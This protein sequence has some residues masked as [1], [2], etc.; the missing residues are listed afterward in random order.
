[1]P[2][3]ARGVVGYHAIIATRRQLSKRPSFSLNTNER[4]ALL[5]IARRAVDGFVRDGMIPPIDSAGL[6]DALTTPCG[7]FVTLTKD[8][9][10]RGCVG[11]FDPSDPLYRVVQQMA[12]ASATQDTRFDPVMPGELRDLEIEVSVLS[13]MKKVN[14]ID[15]IHLGRHGIYLRKGARSGTFLPKVAAETGW[16]KEEFLGHCARDKAGIGWDGWK[17]AE[18]YVYEALVF[19][20]KELGARP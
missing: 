19:K 18:I 1:M 9:M 12:I 3:S 2:G 10:L 16:T 8:G 6:S 13:P 17:D 14:S 7:A 11:R 20:E 4:V 15:E 5:S